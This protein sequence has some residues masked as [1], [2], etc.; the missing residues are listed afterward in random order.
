MS[1]SPY[2]ELL[3]GDL[4]KNKHLTAEQL[5]TEAEEII[6]DNRQ[7]IIFNRLSA[8]INRLQT[9]LNGDDFLLNNVK[10]PESRRKL[11]ER[12]N[13][14]MSEATR[15]L[16]NDGRGKRKR[17]MRRRGPKRRKGTRRR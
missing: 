15:K 17:T 6:Y 12:A 2:R 9:F 10:N 3:D 11:V 4:D 14:V 1:F 7:R 8:I 5:V 16:N 13:R